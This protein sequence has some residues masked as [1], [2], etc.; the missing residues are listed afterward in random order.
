MFLYQMSTSLKMLI[1]MPQVDSTE[2]LDISEIVPPTITVC[3]E[4]QVSLSRLSTMRFFTWFD[5]LTGQ[6]EDQNKTL[7]SWTGGNNLT[8]EE[9][10]HEIFTSKQLM[11]RI[12][13]Y[14]REKKVIKDKLVFLPNI[15]LCKQ[16]TDYN[17]ANIFQIQIKRRILCKLYSNLILKLSPNTWGKG[18][19]C[20]NICFAL[21]V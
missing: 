8:F 16:L 5:F 20:W 15:G 3:P 11:E 9:T 19:G 14:D 6:K 7:V 4:E 17:P 18:F 12:E 21:V 2:I 10:I 1:A 13:F